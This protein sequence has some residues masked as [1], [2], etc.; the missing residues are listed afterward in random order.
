MGEDPWIW[1]GDGTLIADLSDL[2]ID[3]NNGMIIREYNATFGGV[4]ANTP[5]FRERSSSE[6]FAS[7]WGGAPTSYCLVPPPGVTSFAVGD[8]VELLV[9]TVI[10]PKM[11]GDYYGPNTNFATALTIFD[12]SVN[13][14]FREVQGNDIELT[15]PTNAVDATYPPT[16]MTNNNTALVT[17]AG[18]RGYVPLVFKGL[19]NVTDPQL[20]KSE[21]DCWELVDQSLWGKDFWQADYQAKTGLFDLIYNVNQDI[22]GDGLA[23]KSY[24]LGPV[25]P[26]PTIIV[27]TNYNYEGWTL[28]NILA[29]YTGDYAHFAPAIFEGGVVS[30][31]SG[32]WEWTGPN[33]FTASTRNIEFL[34][35]SDVDL[36]VYT[37]TYT[38]PYGCTVT[39]LFELSC[40]ALDEN[41]NCITA[42]C[43]GYSPTAYDLGGIHAV[44]TSFQTVTYIKSVAT[45][46]PGISINYVAGD[47][48][49]LNAGFEV[50]LGVNF[51]A[52]IEDCLEG[53]IVNFDEDLDT[54]LQRRDASRLYG[55]VFGNSN[56]CIND[57]MP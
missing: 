5:Y 24:Y 16:I 52:R 13:L 10:L 20:W 44:D 27:Q 40:T 46:D 28:E 25:P 2:D 53:R 43:S 17:V 23:T 15:S 7:L 31:D 37:V 54:K 30:F 47:S 51:C 19:D 3:T 8:S 12:N 26:S 57:I 32:Q 9:E 48:I 50:P 21:N 22:A 14:F 49:V 34:S 36:G 55:F 11:N 56:H 18:G 1:A 4:S 45:I 6:G 29:V 41:G 39:Q 38:N 33:N 35:I 42:A